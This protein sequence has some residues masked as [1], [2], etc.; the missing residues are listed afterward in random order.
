VATLAQFRSRVSSKT[1]LDNT[2]ASA[3]Q[4]LMDSWINEG[5]I[6]VLLAL[7]C[8][9]IDLQL[10]LTT[11]KGDYTLDSSI[12][13]IQQLF[14]TDTASTSWSMQRCDPDEILYMR[15]VTAATSAPP[16]FYAL[17]GANMLMVYPTP[18]EADVITVY[19]VPRPTALSSAG[20]DPSAASLGGVPTE[21]HKLIEWWACAEAADFTDSSNSQKGNFYLQKFAAKVK[22]YRRRQLLKGGKLPRKLPGNLARTDSFRPRNDIDIP[23]WN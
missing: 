23:N 8:Y 9:V 6:E 13:D 5:V 17:N 14:V 20:D 21:Y 16:R 10:T 19:Y 2:A 3:E 22:D 1:G 11:G 12:L 15:R 4:V 18:Q 7:R